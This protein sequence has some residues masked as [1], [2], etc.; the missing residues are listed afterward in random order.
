MPD[1]NL[2]LVLLMFV[3]FVALLTTGYPVAFVLGGTGLVFALLGE[4]FNHWGYDVDAGLSYVGL[5]H[6][7]MYGVM[8]SYGLVPIPL[9]IFM[10]HMLDR[11][12]LAH[13]LLRAAQALFGPVPGGLAI[14][15]TLIG[16][17][18]AASTG[19]SSAPR[20]FCWAPSPCR[21]CSKTITRWN[22]PRARCARRARW[23][24]SCRP[25]SCS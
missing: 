12:G 8:S 2:V 22:S 18:L 17:I 5:V 19:E 16:L 9:F 20:W 7:R 21:R 25:A 1:I 14:S 11:S 6:N 10:G 4:A 23:A 13:G 24:S 15:V 3:T